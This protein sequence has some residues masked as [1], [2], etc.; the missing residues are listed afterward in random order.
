MCGSHKELCRLGIELATR[1]LAADHPATTPSIISDQLI[2]AVLLFETPIVPQTSQ[3]KE[4]YC[5]YELFISRLQL[6]RLMRRYPAC[7][8]LAQ[9]LK[10]IFS[11]SS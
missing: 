2:A 5:Q 11:A 6:Q 8:L 10:L 7:M 9:S 3:I 4:K 1:C